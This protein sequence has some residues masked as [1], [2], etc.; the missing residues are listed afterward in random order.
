[1]RSRVSYD[2]IEIGSSD[3]EFIEQY[4]DDT[5]FNSGIKIKNLRKVR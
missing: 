4:D 1:M 5:S 3:N 2:D